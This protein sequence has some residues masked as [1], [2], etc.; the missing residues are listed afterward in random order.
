MAKTSK[1]PQAR[2]GRSSGGWTRL[3]SRDLTA[4]D[5]RAKELI[6]NAMEL[7]CTG[8]ISSRHHAILRNA[9]GGTT[10]VPRNLTSQNRTSQNCEAGVRRLLEEHRQ[11]TPAIEA[12][13]DVGRTLRPSTI[14]VKEAFLQHGAAFSSWLDKLG[15]GL[16]ADACI[17]VRESADGAEFKVA[18][19]AARHSG[20][21]QADQADQATRAATAQDSIVA[22][23]PWPVDKPQAMPESEAAV[24]TRA[25][26]G[27]PVDIPGVGIA[28][29]PTEANEPTGPTGPGEPRPAPSQTEDAA[30]VL[31]RIRHVL[32]EDPRIAVLAARVDELEQLN[33]QLRSDLAAEKARADEAVARNQIIRDALDL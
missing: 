27:P 28:A 16:P 20:S 23:A 1:P 18:D 24:Q 17:E 9:A 15:H 22:P 25:Q 3:T 4:F 8:K 21:N 14:T 29:E 26:A 10:S 6:L 5:Q 2:S 11:A 7:G 32:G 30:S 12:A 31:V 13:E 19:A 33:G